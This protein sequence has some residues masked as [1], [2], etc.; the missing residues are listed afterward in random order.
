[1]NLA[2]LITI[3]IISAIVAVIS[4]PVIKRARSKENCCGT[5]KVK[6]KTKK[7]KNVAG[8]YRLYIEGMKCQNCRKNATAA[9]NKIEGLS[10]KVNLEKQEAIVSYESE[11]KTEQAIK[12]LGE[13][14][15]LAK[16]E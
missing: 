11:P 3:L 5:E 13:L 6:I 7:L 1:M 2:S 15:F 8:T 16:V 10:A 14:N 12:A 4:F 9:I